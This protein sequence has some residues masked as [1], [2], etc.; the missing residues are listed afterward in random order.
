MRKWIILNPP[1][2]DYP[3]L[4]FRHTQIN[5][6]VSPKINWVIFFYQP[7]KRSYEVT[8]VKIRVLL[9]QS[10]VVIGTRAVHSRT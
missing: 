6:I 10:I 7:Y 2:N 9:L 4:P 8:K 3:Y 1:P 5:K